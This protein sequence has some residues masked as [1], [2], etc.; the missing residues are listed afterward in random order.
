MSLRP[1]QPRR[2]PSR[3]RS[4]SR[5]PSHRVSHAQTGSGSGSRG[6]SHSA[7]S[8]GGQG[9]A[10]AARRGSNAP[11]FS[12]PPAWRIALIALA[13]VVGLAAFGLV[14]DVATNFGKI[15]RGVTVQGVDLGGLTRADAAARLEEE[16]GATIASAPVELFATEELRSVGADET[17]VELA[18]P[19]NSYSTDEETAGSQSWRISSATV[20]ATVAGEVLIERAYAVGRGD[21]FFPGRLKA[22]FFGVALAGE[23]RYE[24]LQLEAFE[25][26]LCDALGW[27]EENAD[28]RFEDGKFVVVESK[29]GYGADHAAL[30]A[31]LDNAF[32]GTERSLVVPMAAIPV[33]VSDEEAAGVAASVQRAI[34]QPVA[35]AYEN[36]EPW[37][38]TAENLGPWITTSVA[39]EKEQ[40]RLVPSVAADRLKEGIY[41]VIGDRDPG[42]RP[43][44]ARFEVVDGNITV[45]A[46]VNGTGI[47]YNRVAS[48]LNAV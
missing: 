36:E 20:G 43:Q 29:E 19:S 33:A 15:H 2:A 25:A 11:R 18:G 40:A 17:I 47:D 8:R 1:V 9:Q 44:D 4:S 16:L 37:S 48:D 30:T 27:R 32:F 24:P 35:L 5:A 38:L 7:S 22:S 42:I 10:A 28:I 31:A 13:V 23:L 21:D 45:V 39:G 34:E 6:S 41:N 46:S 26:L 12:R 3:S 14:F